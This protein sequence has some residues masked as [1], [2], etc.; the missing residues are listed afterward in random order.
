L[1]LEWIPSHHKI[2]GNER[3][4]RLAKRACAAALPDTFPLRTITHLKRQANER[5]ASDVKA[6]WSQTPPSGAFGVAD[7]FPPKRKPPAH[8]TCTP[9]EVYGRLIQARTGHAFT[10]EYYHKMNI[11][12]ES[13]GCPCGASLQ[14]R[15]HVI[16]T[17]PRYVPYRASI[18]EFRP[19]ETLKRTLGSAEGIAAFTTFL[20]CSRAFTKD[21][22]P[23]EPP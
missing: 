22:E 7:Q 12:E 13:E 15:A 20:Q 1:T 5:L 19:G 8:F 9:R 16:V 17:C 2:P 11:R 21:G 10:G 3:A 6:K 14:T 23:P 18:M 4:D